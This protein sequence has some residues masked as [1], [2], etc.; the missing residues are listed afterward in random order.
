MNTIRATSAVW[1]CILAT[2]ASGCST[3]SST[4]AWDALNPNSA[5][6]GIAAT[7][8]PEPASLE[9]L[10]EASDVVLSG[11]VTEVNAGPVD[12]PMVDPEFAPLA[13][14]V[15]AVDYSSDPR[16]EGTEVKVISARDPGTS[17]ETLDEDLAGET[18]MLFVR[19][20]ALEGYYDRFSSPS[21]VVETSDGVGVAGDPGAGSVV[22][23]GTD[24]LAE[25]ED[26]V[27]LL[28]E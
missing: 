1:L 14:L 11:T 9:S 26:E 22:P 20:S 25:L 12:D 18:A 15:I 5:T 3:S 8:E 2:L 17:V 4:Q 13:A 28:T 6:S 24:S 21:I 19:V 7:G 27:R 23:S 10:V 16:L